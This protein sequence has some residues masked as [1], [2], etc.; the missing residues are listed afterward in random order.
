MGA[1]LAFEDESAV[2]DIE[3]EAPIEESREN[4]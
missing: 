3:F 1:G 2:L 4:H